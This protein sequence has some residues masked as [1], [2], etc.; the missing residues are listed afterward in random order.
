MKKIYIM[1]LLNLSENISLML[2]LF[3]V[4]VKTREQHPSDMLQSV[5]VT[6]LGLLICFLV[7]NQHHEFRGLAIELKTPSG[8]G[9]LSNNQATFLDAL[10]ANNFKIIVSNNYE[11]L[12]ILLHEY[13]EGF[14]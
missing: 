3:L 2:L 8:K 4:W 12:I 1:P 11:E 13:F 6:L 10:Q 7:L 9:V 14:V 5:R